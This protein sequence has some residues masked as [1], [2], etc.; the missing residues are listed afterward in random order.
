MGEL[1]LLC[2]QANAQ[3]HDCKVARSRTM[4]VPNH[5][6]SLSYMSPTLTSFS[7]AGATARSARTRCCLSRWRKLRPHNKHSPTAVQSYGHLTRPV[8]PSR[9]S[10]QSQSPPLRLVGCGRSESTSRDITSRRLHQQPSSHSP[11]LLILVGHPLMMD[12][13][14]LVHD[15]TLTSPPG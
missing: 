14:L 4:Y 11:C 9:P 6:F 7:S 13:A 3:E 12:R 15:S 1:V 8:C 10:S 2:S 5:L